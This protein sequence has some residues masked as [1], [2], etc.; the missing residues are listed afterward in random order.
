MPLIGIDEFSIDFRILPT[1]DVKSIAL[2][3]QTNYISTPEKPLIEVIIPGFTGSVEFAYEPLTIIIIT[4]DTLKLTY[5]NDQGV[6]A[7][8]PDGV[9]QIIMKVCPYGELFNKKC[10]LKTT[11]LELEYQDILRKV[12][13]K[14]N[15]YEERKLRDDIIDFD[16]LLQSA[17]AEADICNTEKALLKYNAACKKLSYINKRLNCE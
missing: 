15:C 3:D 11:K 2:L 6:T 4:S 7:D 1:N 13:I 12:D 16:I 5:S 10:H 9:Y 14:C 17:K 8:L